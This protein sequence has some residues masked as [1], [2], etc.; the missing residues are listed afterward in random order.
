MWENTDVP[1][2]F[3]ANCMKKLGRLWKEWKGEAKKQGYQPFKTNEELLV[4]R[5]P[6]VE[7]DQWPI[8]YL[9]L[10]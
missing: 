4:N 7:E 8:L 10:E 6:R 9:I 3:K 5:P 2:N 1:N